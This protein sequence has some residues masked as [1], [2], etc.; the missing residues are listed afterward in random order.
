M[1][2]LFYSSPAQLRL[3]TITSK[4]RIRFLYNRQLSLPT[5]GYRP[6]CTAV[7]G[8]GPN[9]PCRASGLAN[10]ANRQRRFYVA[11]LASAGRSPRGAFLGA[12]QGMKTSN[13]A[14]EGSLELPEDG[15]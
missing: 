6:Y 1:Q 11:M 2:Q 9:A 13:S 3:Y 14:D 4:Q 5:I 15:D 10:T 8:S 7:W 12:Y